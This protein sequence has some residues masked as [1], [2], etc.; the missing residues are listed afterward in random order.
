MIRIA[1]FRFWV[2][3]R[4]WGLYSEKIDYREILRIHIVPTR[5]N[6]TNLSAK[7]NQIIL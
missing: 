4:L 2:S 5:N 6:N 7:M 3:V 1:R